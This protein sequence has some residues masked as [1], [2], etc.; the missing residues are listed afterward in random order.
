MSISLATVE[1]NGDIRKDPS[2]FK[3]V[4]PPGGFPDEHFAYVLREAMRL[5]TQSVSTPEAGGSSR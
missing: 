2:T 3:I 1:I 4:S 5:L